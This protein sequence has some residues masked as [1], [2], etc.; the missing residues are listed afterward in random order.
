VSRISA[1]TG[2]T[3]KDVKRL[4]E[5]DTPDDTASQEGFNRGMRVISGWL[6]D[7]WF[8]DSDG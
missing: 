1:L 8:L 3:R 5:L 6:D 4:L 2:L 7:R